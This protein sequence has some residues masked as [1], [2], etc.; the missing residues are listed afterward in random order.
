MPYAGAP[1][2]PLTAEQ[3][4]A[5]P[6]ESADRLEL[7]RGRVVREPPPT[8]V[9]GSVV[10]RLA[11]RLGGFVERAGLGIVMMETGF[12]LATDPDTVRAP[13]LSFVAKDR[14][15]AFDAGGTYWR[16]APDLAVEI[17]SPSSTASEVQEKVL[18]YLGA[19]SRMVWVVDPRRRTITIYRSPR[20]IRILSAGEELMGDDVLPG[21]AVGV[22]EVFG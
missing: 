1:S 13:D 22:D 14:I 16:L 6:D 7:M 3:F 20:E 11:V 18:D 10:T 8:P 2:E 5:L 19:G 21:F 4:A 17:L 12:V 15:P 9:H